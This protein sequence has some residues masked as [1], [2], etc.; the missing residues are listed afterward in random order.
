MRPPLSFRGES[1][2]YL[3][4]LSAA[5]NVSTDVSEQTYYPVIALQLTFRFDESLTRVELPAPGDPT[6]PR[7]AAAMQGA[8]AP[9][10]PSTANPN[11]LTFTRTVVAKSCSITLPRHREAATWKATFNYRD[12]PVRPDY[13]KQGSVVVL[14]GTVTA[15]QFA[16]LQ[17]GKLDPRVFLDLNLFDFASSAGP[18][19]HTTA[20]TL[21]GPID[22]WD[23]DA[24]SDGT[25][26][27]VSGRDPIGLLANAPF[28]RANI[29]ALNLDR[30]IDD[31]VKQIL[32]Y[33]P[34]HADWQSFVVCAPASSW[35]KHVIPIVAWDGSDPP[36]RIKKRK[37]A[38][39]SKKPPKAS[40][41][42]TFWDLITQMTFIV[43]AIPRWRGKFLEIVPAQGLYEQ[44]LLSGNG[45]MPTPFKGG[46][47][48]RFSDGSELRVRQLVLGV[49]IDESI[50]IRRS[51]VSEK[52]QVVKVVSHVP[53]RDGRGR[54][55]LLEATYPEDGD[56]PMFP[57][58][59][60]TQ[61]SQDGKH[62]DQANLP[63]SVPGVDNLD[64]LKEIAKAL[65]TERQRGEYRGTASLKR[66][67]S[68][69]GGA[70][71]P[72]LLRL[73]P[74]DAIEIVSQKGRGTGALHDAFRESQGDRS[75]LV[76]ELHARFGGDDEAMR[77]ANVIAATVNDDI[78]EVERTYY[79]TSVNIQGSESNGIDVSF[80]FTTY[81][82]TLR[83][84]PP[85]PAPG[86]RK[87][88]G[89]GLPPLTTTPLKPGVHVGTKLPGAPLLEQP[90]YR[91]QNPL[92]GVDQNAGPVDYRHLSWRRRQNE[93]PK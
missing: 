34:V 64:R 35:P 30:P 53:S 87:S 3:R 16:A 12:L 62:T 60:I 72:D 67:A 81:P 48:R 58:E 83:P 78:A 13:I 86:P 2:E 25:T 8:P 38:R 74:G 33:H 66:L 10:V 59:T 47:P 85:D 45:D 89:S 37:K 14:M 52:A 41:D 80:E 61:V 55:K 63:I 50:Q 69:G 32:S 24:N 92:E 28:L 1:P 79:V 5:P 68:Q 51:F 11:Q 31:V 77:L 49:D 70:R 26:I 57:G 36:D 91:V 4:T 56:L 23:F 42:L 6:Q 21:M 90:V 39:K 18:E 27:E 54:A 20:I 65:F 46:G 22:E 44:A 15:A 84:S 93:T 7:E 29:D 76:A 9:M 40:S 17:T 71:D 43:G 75:A 82:R 88:L 19:K 73:K